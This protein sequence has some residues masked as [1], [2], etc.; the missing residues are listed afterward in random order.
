MIRLHCYE[1][2]GAVVELGPDDLTR[3]VIALGSTG[4]GKTTALINPVLQRLIS[5]RAADPA[6]RVGL[7]VLDPKADDSVEKVRAYARAAGREADVVELSADGDAWYDLLGGFSRLEQSHAFAQRLLSGT[8]DLGMENAYWTESRNG[9][10]ETAL[11]ILLANGSP[12]RFVEAISFMQ[13]WWFSPEP[14]QLEPKLR[15]V[16]QL[17]A[18]GALGH[19]SRRRLELALADVKNWAALDAR[20]RELHRSTLLNAVR[21]LLSSTAHKFFVP[22]AMEF[23]A[24]EVLD[25]KILVVSVDA[26][27]YPDLARLLFRTIRQDFYRAV[28]SRSVVRPEIDRLCGLIADELPLSVMPED[29]RALSVIRAK[30]GFVLAAAQSFSGLDQVLGWRGREALMANFN[31]IFFFPARE[32]AVDEYACLTLGTRKTRTRQE[33]DPVLGD[34]LEKPKAEFGLREAICL[35]GTLARLKAHQAFVKLPDGT[36][37]ES[38]VWLQPCFFDSKRK[39]LVMDQ[40]DLSE[41]VERLKKRDQNV[42]TENSDLGFFLLHMHRNGHRLVVTPALVAALW[43]V[44]SP[45]LSRNRYLSEFERSIPGAN[46]LPSCWLAG[47]HHWSLQNPALSAAIVVLELR[48]GILWPKLDHHLVSLKDGAMVIPESLNLF[49][50]PSLWRPLKMRDRVK[51]L[52]ERPDLR[53][54]I[55]SLPQVAPF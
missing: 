42:R 47:L 32:N 31:S 22:K 50:Y 37:T 19:L 36:C 17:L 24:H 7:V 55:L 28:Q 27:S 53:E 23:R 5:W 35:P 48:S 14:A 21:P 10:L 46:L 43:P 9:F 26:I 13:A 20:T 8:R 18:E 1:P 4:S 25:G 3:H 39:H 41:A 6:G 12:V 15:F 2:A 44:H 38:P 52:L 40:D 29:V 16:G 49:L 51:L 11:V 30:G 54:E 45:K 34:L 33:I